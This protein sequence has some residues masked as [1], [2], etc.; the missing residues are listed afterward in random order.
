E[1]DKLVEAPLNNVGGNTYGVR[2]SS[3]QYVTFEAQSNSDSSDYGRYS[4]SSLGQCGVELN[5]GVYTT[6]SVRQ[7]C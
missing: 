6:S 2:V 4:L 5:E 3:G 1:E 7:D